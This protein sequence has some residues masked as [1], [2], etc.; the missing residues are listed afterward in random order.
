[1]QKSKLKCPRCKQNLKRSYVRKND[2]YVDCYGRKR[3]FSQWI[4]IGY[5]CAD[6]HCYGTFYMDKDI[7]KLSP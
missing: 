3:W 2:F 5:V 7:E 4:G 1:M 6:S